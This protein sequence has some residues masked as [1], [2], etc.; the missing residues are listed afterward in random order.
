VLG[1]RIEYQSDEV[2]TVVT[3][4]SDAVAAVAQA[5]AT[6][7]GSAKNAKKTQQSFHSM[8]CRTLMSAVQVSVPLTL[9]S[10]MAATLIFISRLS[11]HT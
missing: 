9:N 8:L 5:V 11:A 1:T 3:K 2:R 10:L 4:R 7:K 6:T